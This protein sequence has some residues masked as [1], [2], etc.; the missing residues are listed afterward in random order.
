MSD[1]GQ[2]QGYAATQLVRSDPYLTDE[3]EMENNVQVEAET[4]E[5]VVCSKEKVPRP[6]DCTDCPSSFKSKPA[7]KRHY[8]Q[9]HSNKDKDG[10]R[11]R[12]FKCP[13]CKRTYKNRD[14][15]MFHVKKKHS[16]DEGALKWIQE[17][18][19]LRQVH[20]FPVIRVMIKYVAFKMGFSNVLL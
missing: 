17:L 2:L 7:L 15:M 11:L 5:E 4:A 12:P 13:C 18:K 19:I 6:W 10:E 16:N 3:K 14:D 20:S 8:R 1:L 9:C